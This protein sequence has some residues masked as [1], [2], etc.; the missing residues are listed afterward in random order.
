MANNKV[1]YLIGSLVNREYV[2]E[3]AQE[4]R[5]LQYEVFDD[6]TTPGPKA[7]DF[8][9]EY[10]KKRGLDYRTALGSHAAQHIFHFDKLHLDRADIV[11][12]VMPSGKSGHLELGYSIGKGKTGYILMDRE[13]DRVD[14]MHSFADEIFMKKEDLLEKLSWDDSLDTVEPYIFLS[15]GMSLEPGALN[16]SDGCWLPRNRSMPQY[17]KVDVV[18]SSTFGRVF[19]VN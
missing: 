8:F 12:L 10:R 1:I 18:K 16:Y 14:I 19:H 13:P 11:I 2:N 7:D 3:L 15:D 17:V 5:K 4:I 9:D 6:W